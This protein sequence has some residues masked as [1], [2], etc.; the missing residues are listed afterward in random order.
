MTAP[1]NVSTLALSQHLGYQGL[2]GNASLI[3]DLRQGRPVRFPVTFS[4]KWRSIFSGKW[5][6]ARPASFAL[7]SLRKVRKY[8]ID[9]D[10]APRPP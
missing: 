6:T 2:L 9:N 5:P 1:A 10:D 7:S 4:D 3:A 8:E